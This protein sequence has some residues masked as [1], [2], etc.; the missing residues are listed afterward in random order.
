MEEIKRSGFNPVASL[1]D[2]RNYKRFY[3]IESDGSIVERIFLDVPDPSHREHLIFLHYLKHLAKIFKNQ[4]IGINL[5]GRDNPWDFRIELSTDEVF[6]IEI[7][8][9]A[10][11]SK[12]FEIQKEKSVS[13]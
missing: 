8:S 6:N 13:E 4:A 9:I 11:S 12:L 10:D 7:T 2:K 3:R 1:D 5:L